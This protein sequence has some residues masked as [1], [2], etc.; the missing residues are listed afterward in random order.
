M[1]LANGE[2][3]ISRF[4][5]SL[6]KLIDFNV[7]TSKAIETKNKQVRP[8]HF[9]LA[10][11][12]VEDGMAQK[13]FLERKVNPITVTNT[14]IDVVYESDGHIC[15]DIN[16]K[17]E[18]FSP[19]CIEFL[20]KL[21][22]KSRELACS[23]IEE[24]LLLSVLFTSLEPKVAEIFE[25]LKLKDISD[26]IIDTLITGHL[27]IFDDETGAV[28]LELFDQSG[29]VFLTLL[30]KV[31]NETGDSKI[32]IIHT[33]I[34]LALT[35]YGLLQRG[36]W[37]QQSDP[38]RLIEELKNRICKKQLQQEK[39][40]AV[41]RASCYGSVVSALETAAKI[42][43]SDGRKEVGE[44]QLLRALIEVDGNEG[45][46]VNTL[47]QLKVNIKELVRYATKWKPKD[48]VPS[49]GVEAIVEE[50]ES[51]I[52]L[53]EV[54]K[55]VRT[56]VN[57][58]KHAE[59]KKK[60]GLPPDIES[61]LHMVF[62]GN[63]GTG[64]T[65]IARKMG[66]IFRALGILNKGHCVE[67]GRTELVAQYVG[68]TAVKTKSK[69]TEAFD[70]VLFID[71]A[72]TLSKGGENDFGKEAIDQILKMMEDNRD[73]LV[74]IVAGYPNEMRQFIDS[75]PG[76][77]SRF[78]QYVTFEDYSY[79]EL[80]EIFKKFCR[81]AQY[82]LSPEALEKLDTYVKTKKHFGNARDMRNLFQRVKE[83]LSNRI[84]R[85]ANPTSEDISI[86]MPEDIPY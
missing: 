86:I 41:S 42:T 46:F 50:I 43:R 1:F 65:T 84:A 18:F 64:K 56:Q 82:T 53:E 12:D 51:F 63:P 61:S 26:R 40:S 62:T 7:L 30:C 15:L 80:F 38:S 35:E 29:K 81:I 24:P 6:T 69:V 71:E 11:L 8:S 66:D 3:D 33:G 36:L 47:S 25:H 31:A 83:S 21:D 17:K 10:L 27:N 4:S 14:V 49:V 48:P 72:Y 54:K 58:L 68:Q 19:E 60:H 79:E 45:A 28:N 16:L 5:D 55:F 13:I 52:G 76:L 85:L 70:G 73:R 2:F 57:V 74:V 34:A 75:N 32:G 78:T 67:T 20:N 77:E 37:N 44:S 39:V 59:L 9:L 22:A 23:R